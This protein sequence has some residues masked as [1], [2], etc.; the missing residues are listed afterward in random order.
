MSP[1]FFHN[2]SG[3]GFELPKLDLASR[4]NEERR[5]Y[6][7]SR[8]HIDFLIHLWQPPFMLRLHPA[9]Y[10]QHERTSTTA[11]PERSEAK[12]KG[13]LRVVTTHLKK[14]PYSA[15]LSASLQSSGTHKPQH[16]VHLLRQHWDS[17]M[18]RSPFLFSDVEQAGYLRS[19]HAFS[20]KRRRFNYFNRYRKLVFRLHAQRGCVD[21]NVVTF[22]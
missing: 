21:G 11:R 20:D 7:N 1:I 19:D 17:G 2:T 8:L 16:Q 4:M 14:N 5:H 22:P 15:H 9:G 3:L 18:N 6:N 10:A 12:S 13:E